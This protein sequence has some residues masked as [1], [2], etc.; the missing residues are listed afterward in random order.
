MYTDNILCRPFGP[1][2]KIY[3]SNDSIQIFVQVSFI[4]E[5]NICP[6][7]TRADS[8]ALYKGYEF[9]KELVANPHWKSS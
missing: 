5:S 7:D 8:L 3:H 2:E 6:N 4:Y 1:V 9:I